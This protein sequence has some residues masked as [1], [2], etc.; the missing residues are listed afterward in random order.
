MIKLNIG[1]N[2]GA[3]SIRSRIENIYDRLASGDDYQRNE[4]KLRLIQI[5]VITLSAAGT[6]YVNAFAHKERI[7]WIGAVMLAILIM[8]FVEVFYFTLRHGLSTTYKSGLQRLFAR[9]SYRTIQFTMILNAAVLCSWITGVPMPPFLASWNRLSI[10]VYF[11]M[12]LLGVAAVR[13]SSPVVTHRILELKAET[14]RQDIITIRKA[15]MIGNPLVLFAAKLRGF[16]DGVRLARDLLGGKVNSPTYNL[17]QTGKIPTVRSGQIDI[18]SCLLLPDASQEFSLISNINNSDRVRK[19]EANPSMSEH[20]DGHMGE[21]SREYDHRDFLYKLIHQ[22][23]D[24]ECVKDDHS[25]V[26]SEQ[27]S[28]QDNKTLDP[29]IEHPKRLSQWLKE[30]LPEATNGWWD[31]RDKGNRVELK[32]R[33]RDPNLQVIT[34]LRLT[35]EQLA[36]LKQSDYEEAKSRLRKQISLGLHKLSL[37]PVKRDKTLLV[38]RKLGIDIEQ[39]QAQE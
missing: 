6:G 15:T 12:A 20:T 23:R 1:G 4:N 10:I 33:W 21:K 25:A 3:S 5:C 30:I 24:N 38:A 7:G 29:L 8:G 9:L 17:N 27:P 28:E 32:F 31:I 2:E 26:E 19:S 36:S 39:D 14:A 34:P 13:D 16:L 11:S 18:W 35:S 22:P 37:D